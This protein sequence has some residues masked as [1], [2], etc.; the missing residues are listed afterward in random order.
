MGRRARGSVTVSRSSLE[1]SEWGDV[2]D[3]VGD[4]GAGGFLGGEQGDDRD[5]L[6]AEGAVPDGGWCQGG[7]GSRDRRLRDQVHEAVLD[8]LAAWT[9]AAREQR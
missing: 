5:G 2:G 4:R 7:D 8:A 9:A 3:A 6:V 1:T